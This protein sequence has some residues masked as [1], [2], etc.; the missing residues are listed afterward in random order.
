ML[1]NQDSWFGRFKRETE[2]LAKIRRKLG[3]GGNWSRTLD[4]QHFQNLPFMFLLFIRKLMNENSIKISLDPFMCNVARIWG[5]FDSLSISAIRILQIPLYKGSKWLSFTSSW[6]T[7]YS[8]QFYF[9]HFYSN[10]FL[11]QNFTFL[12]FTARIF[13]CKNQDS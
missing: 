7:K 3:N 4:L 9:Y 2:A 13:F 5:N 12:E 6:C 10:G 8:C 11:A 1:Y